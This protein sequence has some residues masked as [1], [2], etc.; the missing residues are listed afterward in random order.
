[1]NSPWRWAWWWCALS[2]GLPVVQAADGAAGSTSWHGYARE[3]FTVAGRP[4]LLISPHAA[5]P[6]N[7]WVWRAEFFGD[8]HAPQVELALLARG[9]HVAYMQASD[10]YGAPKAIGLFDAFY[11]EL[12]ER[13]G[14][15][16]RPVIEGF[17]RGGLYA[18]NFAA[19]YPERVGALYLD[20]PALDIKSW[21]GPKHPLWKQCLAC[22]GLTEAEA[23]TAKVSPLDRI[24]PVAAAKIPIIGVA[25]DADETVKPAENLLKLEQRYRALGGEIEV[26]IKPGGKHHP[27][28]LPDPT[29][30]VTFIEA[31]RL[32]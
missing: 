32:K 12:V 17:S 25:G 1:M 20:A 13:R 16:R 19:T 2:C 15:A 27:H 14:L 30:I 21:P 7:P 11:R 10:M 4:C 3:D 6:G 22:Y 31:K 26:I 23:M 29:P 9:W 8:E 28:S 5:A 24:A 18:F